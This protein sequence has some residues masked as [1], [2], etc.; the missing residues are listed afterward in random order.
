MS[1]ILYEIADQYQFLLKDLYDEET[2]VVNEATFAKLN[3][4]T[5]SIE[6]KAINITKLF[7]EMEAKADAIE[8]ERQA[9]QKR[10]RSLKNQIQ[11]LKNYLSH[12][13]QRCN[14]NK[15][16]CPQ[17]VISLHKN[18]SKLDITDERLIPSKYEITTLSLD[19]AKIKEDLKNGIEIPGAQLVN[20]SSI[21]IR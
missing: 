17:F 4:I 14:I 12:N 11:S 20:G 7:K 5:D 10:E 8:R 1:L 6:D 15:I 19:E 9:M 18:P 16:E 21:R 2:G 13:M 3:E